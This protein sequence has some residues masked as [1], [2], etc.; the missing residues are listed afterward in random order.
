MRFFFK[1]LDS[2]MRK[3]LLN[4]LVNVWMPVLIMNCFCRVLIHSGE[5]C[6]GSQMYGFRL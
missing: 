2:M 3:F 4:Y 5:K 1:K 6:W